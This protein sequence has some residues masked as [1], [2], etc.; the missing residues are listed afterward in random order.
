MLIMI[1]IILIKVKVQNMKLISPIKIIEKHEKNKIIIFVALLGVMMIPTG[2]ASVNLAGDCPGYSGV[3]SAAPAISPKLLAYTETGTY[4]RTISVV[5][6]NQNPTTGNN[7]IP[8]V[9]MICKYPIF[10]SKAITSKVTLL[11]PM[12]IGPKGIWAEAKGC[13]KDDCIRI[14]RANENGNKNN[15]PMNGSTFTA[16]SVTFSTQ[17]DSELIVAHINWPAICGSSGTC[18][19][20]LS[21]ALPALK[22][23]KTANP[24][25]YTF[26]GQTITYN[27]TIN[28]TGNVI[29]SGPFSVFDNKT[30]VTCPGTPTSLNPGVSI[31]CSASYSV[32][33]ADLNAG[34]IINIATAEVYYNG[35]RISSNEDHAIVQKS[36][37]VPPVP[38]LPTIAL[39]GLGILGLLF[40]S[41]KKN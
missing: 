11:T 10:G 5:T 16:G 18:F 30:T 17:P 3:G 8:G 7:I 32:N 39:I 2:V 38:E 21:P 24:A 22:L 34:S 37:P 25:T 29:L 41:S 40:M 20:T 27:Y 31:N 12:Y 19:R 23:T 15:M 26:V 4:I 13:G 1:I 33:Q 6:S 28:N 35:N 9:M 36:S 14:G